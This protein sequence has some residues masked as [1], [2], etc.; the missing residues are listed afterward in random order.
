MEP[1]ADERLVMMYC[2]TGEG[3]WQ[4]EGERLMGAVREILGKGLR[5]C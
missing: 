2:N 4:T 5:D 1:V 3:E